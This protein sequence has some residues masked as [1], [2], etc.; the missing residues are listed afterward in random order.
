MKVDPKAGSSSKAGAAE[1]RRLFDRS[2]PAHCVPVHRAF[3]PDA[4][5]R[6]MH[7]QGTIIL[8]TTRLGV[9]AVERVRYKDALRGARFVTLISSFV[10]IFSGLSMVGTGPG[11]VDGVA[12]ATCKTNPPGLMFSSAILVTQVTATNG[13]AR[14]NSCSLSMPG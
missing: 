2:A 4:G 11:G 13:L 12:P 5:Q 3:T 6:A 8:D 14:Y 1:V 9:F 10:W 7:H